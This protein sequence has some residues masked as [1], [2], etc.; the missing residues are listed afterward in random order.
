MNKSETSTH[1]EDHYTWMKMKTKEMIDVGNQSVLPGRDI[2]KQVRG[3]DARARHS[4][5][6]S[7][8]KVRAAPHKCCATLYSVVA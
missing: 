7:G 4:V 2:L 5:I 1:T 6:I 8:G 3:G